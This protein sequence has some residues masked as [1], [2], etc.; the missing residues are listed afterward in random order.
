MDTPSV[1]CIISETSDGSK[2]KVD[3]VLDIV[4]SD[5]STCATTEL[6]SPYSPRLHESDRRYLS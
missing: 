2:N 3:K 5:F 6:R 4:A 1:V